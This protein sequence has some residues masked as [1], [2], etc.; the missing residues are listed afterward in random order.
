[1]VPRCAVN[2][3]CGDDKNSSEGHAFTPP[4]VRAIPNTVPGSPGV[5]NGFRIVDIPKNSLLSKLGVKDGDIITTVNG[6]AL[7]SPAKAMEFY[8]NLKS[9]QQVQFVI[10]RNGSTL[11]K[12]YN[13]K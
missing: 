4:E 5:I 2:D 10:E 1:M 12:T 3:S 8:N 6:E 9:N 11:T 13:I 7:D